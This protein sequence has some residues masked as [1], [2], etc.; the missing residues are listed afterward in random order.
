MSPTAELRM[1]LFMALILILVGGTYILSTWAPRPTGVYDELIGPDQVPHHSQ[2]ICGW[3]FT[4]SEYWTRCT[5]GPIIRHWRLQGVLG[6]GL[7]M[8]LVMIGGAVLV[9][10]FRTGA[11]RVAPY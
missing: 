3:P 7:I 9:W 6:N 8:A 1:G 4:A 5:T 10:A 2:M 11:W